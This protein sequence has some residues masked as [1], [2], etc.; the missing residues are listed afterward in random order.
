MRLTRNKYH[1]I[2]SNGFD[3]KKEEKRYNELL[4]LQKAKV[5]SNL[6][7]QVEFELQPSFKKNGKTYRKI[8]YIA[9]FVYVNNESGEVIVEDTKG[10]IT[11]VFRIKQKMFEYKYPELK[12]K[13]I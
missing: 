13:I 1:N 11:E 4:L 8:S 12:L 7:L 6:Q 5:I 10:Y 3:S 2:K 9:D